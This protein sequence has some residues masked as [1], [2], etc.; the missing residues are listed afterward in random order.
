MAEIAAD[1]VD[2]QRVQG[3]MHETEMLSMGLQLEESQ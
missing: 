2:H 3:E 1:D